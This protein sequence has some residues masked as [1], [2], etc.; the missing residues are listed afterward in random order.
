MPIYEYQCKKHGRFDS[1][2][3]M[4]ERHAPQACPKC[5]KLSEFVISAPRVFCD[6]TPYISPASGKLIEGRRARTE[7]FARTGTRPYDAG[8]MRDAQTHR[9]LEEA[10]QDAEVEAAVDRTLVE[11]KNG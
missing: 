6:F 8:E 7:D 1:W 4:S 9:K 2:A 10:K 5:H 11:M 3:L